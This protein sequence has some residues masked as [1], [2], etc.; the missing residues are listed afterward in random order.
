M[1]SHVKSLGHKPVIFSPKNGELYNRGLEASI[2]VVPISWKKNNYFNPIFLF[3]LYEKIRN[4]KIDVIIFNSFIDIRDA[5]IVSFLAG[6]KKRILRVGMPIIP[7]KNFTYK[8]SFK[9]GLS[10]F[11]GISNE[12]YNIFDKSGFVDK[13]IKFMIPNGINLS[14][15]QFYPDRFFDRSKDIRFG[16]CVRLSK[17]KGLHGFIEIVEDLSTNFP[18]G[19]FVL[20]GDGE[21]K[22]NLLEY[23]AK[24]SVAN[25]IKFLGH[26]ENVSTFYRNID[27]LIFTSHYEGTARTILEAMSSG[28]LVFCFDTSSMSE[29]I[30]NGFDGF[31]VEP[32][33]YGSFAEK[34]INVFNTYSLEQ[35]REVGRNARK[36]VEEKYSKDKNFN[37]WAEVIL[38]QPNSK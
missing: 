10:H 23:A 38:G 12:I 3:G 30:E 7:K 29:M 32:F 22:E 21:E 1:A 33:D 20:A 27:V 14:K 9:I 28:V 36:T 35:L 5:G 11:V 31:K 8:I 18:K 2:N 16:N 34:I 37:K 6:V 19:S 15:F 26:L 24:K 13:K 17:Q 4:E 25:K